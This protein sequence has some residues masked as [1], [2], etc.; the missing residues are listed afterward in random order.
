[1][2]IAD[3]PRVDDDPIA[4]LGAFSQANPARFHSP[5]GRGYAFLGERVLALDELNPQL[6]ARLVSAFNQWK[7]FEPVRRSA[8]Q[9]ELERI[10]AHAKL[11]RDTGEIVTRALGRA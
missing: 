7:R 6:A 3:T 8:M 10:A 5:D 1:M 4:L 11:S 2:A 9:A